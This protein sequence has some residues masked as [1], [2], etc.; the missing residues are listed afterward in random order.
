MTNPGSSH[1]ATT[2][3]M[4]LATSSTIVTRSTEPWDSSRGETYPAEPTLTVS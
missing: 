2:R 3:P 1:L 4:A